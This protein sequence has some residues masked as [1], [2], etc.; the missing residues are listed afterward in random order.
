MRNVTL[1]LRTINTWDLLKKAF[2]PRY[3]PPSMTA[4]QLKDIHNFKKEGDESLYQAWERLDARFAK[5][6]TSTKTVPST[7]KLN[8]LKRRSDMENLDEQRLLTGIM[9]EDNS[10]LKQLRNTSRK[11]L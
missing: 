2:I 7:R 1:D 9:K 5:D 10:W 6:L 4:K 11:P 8:K 3:C